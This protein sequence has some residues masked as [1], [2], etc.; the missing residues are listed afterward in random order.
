M[1]FIDEKGRVFNKINIL[2]LLFIVLIV[3][4]VFLAMLKISG[5]T[6][7]DLG[8]S[9]ELVNVEYTLSIPM[10]AGYLDV[11]KEGDQ[12]AEVK[13]FLDAYVEDVR[14]EPVVVNNL[15]E[16]GNLV[17]SIDPTMELAHV[18]IRGTVKSEDMSYKL[19]SQ[20][21]RQGK[22]IFLETQFY[23]YEGQIE[24]VKVVD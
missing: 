7:E 17:E 20:E 15:D 11:I 24:S 12:L 9:S 4:L 14:I 19:G 21:L 8:S 3:F 6:L 13:Q 23:K 22:I 16:S 10:D 5:D 2:D 1:K 18:L